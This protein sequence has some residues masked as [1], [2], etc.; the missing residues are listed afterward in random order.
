MKFFVIFFC[1]FLVHRSFAQDSTICSCKYMIR[2]V[3][4]PKKAE[5]NKISGIVIIEWDVSEDGLWSNP[6]VKKSLGYGCD[7]EALKFTRSEI[8]SYNRCRQNC[9]PRKGEKTKMSRSFNFEY[10]QE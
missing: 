6:L 10:M 1:T 3:Q 7:E 5:E 4:Y 8:E 2:S 9:K